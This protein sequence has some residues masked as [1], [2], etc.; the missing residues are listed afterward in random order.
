MKLPS[1]LEALL[2]TSCSFPSMNTS[3]PVTRKGNLLTL[4]HTI[5]F[6]KVEIIFANQI[7]FKVF[8]LKRKLNL[9]I[10]VKCSWVSHLEQ[11]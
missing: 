3:Q 10:T 4:V 6:K 9:K 7:L 1:V 2:S 8:F 11:L 5:T